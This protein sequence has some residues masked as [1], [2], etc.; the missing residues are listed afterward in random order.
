[1]GDIGLIILA[2]GEASRMGR[3]K[4]LLE[5]RGRPLVRHAAETALASVCRPVVVVL[6]HAAATIRPAL[7]GAP[8]AIAENPD[9][10]EGVAGSIR[11]GVRVL[12]PQA[13]DGLIL[14]LADQPLVTPAMLNRLVETH[15]TE[16][17]PIVASEYS[18]T[19][20]VPVF[21]SREFFPHL[22]ALEA[23]QGCKG[24]ILMHR[25][26]ARTIPC[27]EAAVDIDTPADY[28][29]LAACAGPT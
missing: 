24:V 12:A 18:G 23:N 28:E 26:Q 13:V 10:H 27:P 29:R 2:A 3:P 19:V 25:D 16:S 15:R 5:F 20:G 22:L 8:V 6:G 9:W 17:A 7:D 14:M 11:A 1:M 4:Q 21:F